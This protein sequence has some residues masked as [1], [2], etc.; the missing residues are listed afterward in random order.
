MQFYL[1]QRI[2]VLLLIL[3]MIPLLLV[4]LNLIKFYQNSK[5]MWIKNFKWFQNNNFKANPEKY[6]LLTTPKPEVDIE[7][8]GNLIKKVNRTKLLGITIG[9]RLN[10][11]Y[12]TQKLCKKASK[13]LHTLS[14]VS[15]DCK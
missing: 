7:I 12:H 10:S 4:F 11:D 13:K 5:L 15:K 6:H 8:S 2:W 1:K 9:G 3:T 14:R